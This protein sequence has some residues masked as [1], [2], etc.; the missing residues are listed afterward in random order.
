[1]S[2]EQGAHATALA[3]PARDSFRGGG[4][5]AQHAPFEGEERVAPDDERVG[6]VHRAGRCLPTSE[7]CDCGARIREVDIVFGH[8]GDDDLRVEPGVTQQAEARRRCRGEDQGSGSHAS[9]EVYG[10]VGF[11]DR[12]PARIA[13]KPDH[14]Q[15]V[16]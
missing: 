1:M 4:R 16:A 11:A 15:E 10:P 6:G 9:P 8:A 7:G 14:D 5:L 13:A 12:N 3:T 2:R